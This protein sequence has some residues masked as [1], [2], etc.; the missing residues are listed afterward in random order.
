M[1][2]AMAVA[3]V[4]A[5]ILSIVI[6]KKADITAQRVLMLTRL[7]RKLGADARLSEDQLPATLR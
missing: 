4:E 3:T 6:I 7:P 5:N 1:V 2:R